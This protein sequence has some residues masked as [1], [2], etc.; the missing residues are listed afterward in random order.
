MY[1]SSQPSLTPI[2]TFLPLSDFLF[3][4]TIVWCCVCDD[5]Y[6]FPRCA[7]AS[8][9]SRLGRDLLCLW[10]VGGKTPDPKQAARTFADIMH[11]RA[12]NQEQV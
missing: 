10:F 3:S 2:P 12:L 4:V 8:L 11:E 6:L 9:G 5:E 1:S 7:D